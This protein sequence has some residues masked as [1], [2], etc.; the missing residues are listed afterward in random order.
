MTLGQEEPEYARALTIFQQRAVF[1]GEHAP[2]PLE[3]RAFA[4]VQADEFYYKHPRARLF[5]LSYENINTAL[6]NDRPSTPHLFANFEP[7]ALL[8]PLLLPLQPPLLPPLQTCFSSTE[9]KGLLWLTA[10][11]SLDCLLAFF[12]LHDLLLLEAGLPVPE[13]GE[14]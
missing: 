10:A 8:E 12:L 5:L 14:E 2:R 6:M 4:P 3:L 11:A 1:P 13:G 9:T 7:G